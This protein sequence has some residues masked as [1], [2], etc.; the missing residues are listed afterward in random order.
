MDERD[1]A[2]AGLETPVQRS[3]LGMD[4]V[5]AL[6]ERIELAIPDLL[7]LHTHILD[8]EPGELIRVV[9]DHRVVVRMLR[10]SLDAPR[11]AQMRERHA[12]ELLGGIREHG[13]PR[14]RRLEAP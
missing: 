1:Q 2:L 9:D 5:E 13:D 7:A 10:E 11:R 3:E 14:A 6:Q 12:G 4:G 8:F